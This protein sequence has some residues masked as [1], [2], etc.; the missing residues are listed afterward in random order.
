LDDPGVHDDF[1]VHV[2]EA[3]ISGRCS[4]GQYRGDRDHLPEFVASPQILHALRKRGRSHIPSDLVVNQYISDGE[5]R[6]VYLP[7]AD[8]YR[9]LTRR[10][11]QEQK[12]LDEKTLMASQRPSDQR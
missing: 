10:L 1:G 8:K 4:E 6:V 5:S 12:G 7:N 3:S 11:S 2:E 9:G